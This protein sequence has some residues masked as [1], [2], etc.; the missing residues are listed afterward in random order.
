MNG[1]ANGGSPTNDV[2]T[3]GGLRVSI[4]GGGIAGMSAAIALRKQGHSVHIYEQSR[5]ANESGAAIH[6]TPNAT[7]LL[8]Y[9]D[10]DPEDTG[11]VPLAEVR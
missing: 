8:R 11:A 7:G 6:S 10:I 9:L 5:F 1:T 3:V 2:K 4:V